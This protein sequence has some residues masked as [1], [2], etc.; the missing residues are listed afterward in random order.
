MTAGTARASQPIGSLS[1]APSTTQA[2]AHPDVTVEIDL[3]AEPAQA[4]STMVFDWP[5]GVILLPRSAASCT[6]SDFAAEECPSSSQI[7][8][9]TIHADDEGDPAHLLGTAAVY[10]LAPDSNALGRV[11]FVIPTT[12]DPVEGVIGL[13]ASSDYGARMSLDGLPEAAA[14]QAAKLTIWGVPPAGEHDPERLPKGTSGCPGLADASC[15]GPPVSSNAQLTAYTE[16]PTDC[17]G[18]PA[19]ELTLN[20]HEDAGHFTSAEA[21]Y[22]QST[23][24]NQISFNPL[25]T[26][27]VDST[28][29][30][31]PTAAELLILD[32]VA[33]A[34]TTPWGA[35]LRAASVYFGEGLE[36]ATASIAS[37]QVCNAPNAGLV[38]ATTPVCPEGSSLGTASVGSP[39][40]PADLPGDIYY[41]GLDPEGGYRAYVAAAGY[42]VRVVLTMALAYEEIEVEDEGGGV[43]ALEALVAEFPIL[44]QIPLERLD[45]EF[46]GGGSAPL[47]TAPECGEYPVFGVAEAWSAVH[48]PWFGEETQVLDAGVGGGPC[49]VPGSG[50]GGGGST[51]SPAPPSGPAPRPVVGPPAVK[52]VRHPPRRS[53]KHRAKFAFRS[54][55]AGATFRCRLDSGRFRRCSSP[56]SYKGLKPAR[57]RFQ[58]YAVGHDGTRGK[59]V[60]FS[61]TTV[62]ARHHHKR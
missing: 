27:S 37:R 56:V 48:S 24:C 5:E 61:F 25:V 53:K 18:S 41:G 17:S 43:E 8:V 54:G 21:P 31:T 29:V 13:R 55:T 42:G 10:S 49:P 35:H 59:T 57:H 44:P 45:L 2:G 60:S 38:P 23:G 19:L 9:V 11:G 51:P 1:V 22:P 26:T 4:V 6:G 14:L 52:I 50:S 20:T 30:L 36:L 34:G 3:G 7:G 15:G 46:A 58:V 16:N 12:G 33:H 32:P 62:K 40:F 47:V 28:E 39:L